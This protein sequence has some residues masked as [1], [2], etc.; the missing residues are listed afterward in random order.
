MIDI[1]TK[2]NEV[3]EALGIHVWLEFPHPITEHLYRICRTCKNIQLSDNTWIDS[4][5]NR[6]Q[7]RRDH[8]QTWKEIQWR[9][10]KM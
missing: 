1:M 3:L 5:F 7:H 10:R 4:S 2:E 6:K 9:I 8:A